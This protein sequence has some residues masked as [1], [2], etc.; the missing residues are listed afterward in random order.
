MKTKAAVL[1]EANTKLEICE[2]DL[3]K[4]Q[5]GEVCVEIKAAGVCPT[6]YSVMK[7]QLN[8]PL[9]AILGHE[10]AGVVAEVG[11][12]VSD[13]QVG[14]HVIPLWRLSCGECEYCLRRRPALCAVGSKIR[15]SGRMSDGRSRFSLNGK[16]IFHFAGVSAFSNFSVLPEGA[17]LKIPKDLPFDLAA[18]IGCSVITGVG[19]VMNAAEMRPGSS[20]AVFGAG[21]IGVNVIQ[22]AT[23]AG[24]KEI[25]AIDQ[26]DSRLHQA[27]TFGATRVINSKNEDPVAAIRQFTNERGVDFAFEAVGLPITIQQAY[28]SLS[29]AGKAIVIGIPSNTAKIS[30]SAVPLVFEERTITGSLYGSASPRLDIPK[31]IN[32]YKDGKLNLEKLLTNQYPLEEI[33]E[34]Y[35]AMMSG[36]SLRSV[37]TF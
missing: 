11:D 17:V 4:P 33:N 5:A 10:G 6:D 20:V 36:E 14:D 22:G 15:S 30:I 28:E 24:A 29:K 19:S 25:I 12:G 21:G 7:G 32:L 9:P 23:L 34:A 37:I 16:E 1:F 8:A 31:M 26:Y 2:V 18:L 3:E 13:V 27:R 35:D